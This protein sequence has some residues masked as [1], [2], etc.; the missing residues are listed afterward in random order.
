MCQ[1]LT[2]PGCLCA[3]SI[4]LTIQAA[5]QAGCCFRHIFEFQG[6]RAG[7]RTPPAGPSSISSLSTRTILTVQ[8]A[9]KW[10]EDSR[11]P[12]GVLSEGWVLVNRGR[13]AVMVELYKPVVLPSAQASGSNTA[14]PWCSPPHTERLPSCLLLSKPA[15]PGVS[16]LQAPALRADNGWCWVTQ[17]NRSSHSLDHPSHCWSN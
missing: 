8:W 12:A 6:G 11:G 14:P 16:W 7:D 10:Q 3:L 13:A 17:L 2:V 1:Q 5:P 9:G 4:Q 15:Q